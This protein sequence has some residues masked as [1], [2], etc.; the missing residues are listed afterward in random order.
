MLQHII[1]AAVGAVV[2]WFVL[3]VT[4]ATASPQYVTAV[5]IG[6]VATILWPLVIGFW[7]GRRAKARRDDQISKEVDAQ[8]K[9]KGG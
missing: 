5:A 2:T 9:A 6:A 7:L 1:G 8:I 3:V 4:N